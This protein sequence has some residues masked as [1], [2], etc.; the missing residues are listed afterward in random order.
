MMLKTA[1]DGDST[2]D[3]R[4]KYHGTKYGTMNRVIVRSDDQRWSQL[5]GGEGRR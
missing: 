2:K 5:T 4:A 1:L 3:E